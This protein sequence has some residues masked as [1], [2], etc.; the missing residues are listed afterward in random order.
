MSGIG[1]V[2]LI[3]YP[4]CTDVPNRCCCFSFYV[5]E[6]YIWKQKVSYK[7]MGLYILLLLL[8]SMEIANLNL[9]IFLLVSSLEWHN[10]EGI[11]SK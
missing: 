8:H 3:I 10:E 2:L 6:F 7:Q 11:K 4:G 9:I 5:S 1:A